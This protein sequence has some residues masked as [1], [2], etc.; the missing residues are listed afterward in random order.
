MAISHLTPNLNMD[1]KIFG[2]T[3]DI[4]E[5]LLHCVFIDERTYYSGS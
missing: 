1:P 3:D 5:I 2:V 4:P